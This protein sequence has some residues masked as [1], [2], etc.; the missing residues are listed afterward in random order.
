MAGTPSYLILRVLL[1]SQNPA[2][3]ETPE[4]TGPATMAVAET[5]AV[6]VT[7]AA[8]AITAEET[9]TAMVQVQAALGMI[10]PSTMQAVQARTPP[11]AQETSAPRAPAQLRPVR[12]IAGGFFMG[13]P[14]VSA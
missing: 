13:Q 3:E 6:E 14:R 10:L 11:L 1:L 2:M 5:A 7:G 8:T 4:G 9:A 12:S